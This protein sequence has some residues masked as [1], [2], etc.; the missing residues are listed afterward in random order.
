VG[1]DTAREEPA[2][3]V[4][5]AAVMGAHGLKGDVR[6]K[7]F[8]EGIASLKRHARLH[9]G[10]RLLTLQSVAAG[11]APIARFAEI[12]DRNAAEALRGSLIS[13]ERSELPPLEEGEYYY[14][15]LI[16]LECV[17]GAGAVLGAVVGVENFGAGDIIEIE[18]PDGKRTMVPYRA[19]IADLVDGRIR[20]DPEFLA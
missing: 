15:D 3:R 13:V 7:L 10:E 2:G 11:K 5:L 18:L 9:V 19:G 6:L 12:S 17:D 14:A 16:G 8:A 1:N 4:I 20:I